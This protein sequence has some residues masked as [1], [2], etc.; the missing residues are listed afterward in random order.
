MEY[1][2]PEDVIDAW[3][4]KLSDFMAKKKPGDFNKKFV[5]L[6]IQ[7]S[8]IVELKKTGKPVSP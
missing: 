1:Q 4:K 5:P 6:I 8:K 2:T 7:M 3:K